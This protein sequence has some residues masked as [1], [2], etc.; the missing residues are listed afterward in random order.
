MA[1]KLFGLQPAALGRLRHRAARVGWGRRTNR[2]RRRT[3]NGAQSVATPGTPGIRRSIKSTPPTSRT[4][5]VVWSWKGD[6]YGTGVEIKN[7]TRRSW[8]TAYCISRPAIGGPSSPLTRA[9][10]RRCGRIG[11]KN[12]ATARPAF[13]EERPRRRVLDEDGRQTKILTIT[14]RLRVDRARREAVARCGLRERRHRRFDQAG[15]KGRELQSGHRAPHEHVAAS[16]LRQRRHDS[17]FA[18]KRAQSEVDEVS[19]SRHDGLRRA[20]REEA[21]ELPHHSTQGRVRPSST[22]PRP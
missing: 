13:A 8:W 15:R 19:E 4:F 6:N 22:A 9:R 21:V 11:S 7:E 20:D 12:Q 14:P 1:R 16:R 5:K 3:A 18:R 17:D 2:A 10:A